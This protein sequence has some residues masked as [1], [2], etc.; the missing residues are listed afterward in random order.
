MRFF[1]SYYLVIYNSFFHASKLKNPSQ[2]AGTRFQTP[3]EI[4]VTT[5][6]FTK[7]LRQR[8]EMEKPAP[9]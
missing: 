1:F 2:L 4:L 7:Q 5:A 9:P 6:H 3:N 8:G